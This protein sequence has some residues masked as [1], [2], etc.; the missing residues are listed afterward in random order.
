MKINKRILVCFTVLALCCVNAVKLRASDKWVLILDG[1]FL[2]K[3]M[4]HISEPIK[5]IHSIDFIT[6]KGTY[7]LLESEDSFKLEDFHAKV[8]SHMRSPFPYGTYEIINDPS[9]GSNHF[10]NDYDDSFMNPHFDSR[11]FS[12]D[13]RWINYINN[14]DNK[15][16]QWTFATKDN[17]IQ[18]RFAQYNKHRDLAMYVSYNDGVKDG[19]KLSLRMNGDTICLENFRKGIRIQANCY[20]EDKTLFF[21]ES[22]KERKEEIWGDSGTKRFHTIVQIDSLGHYNGLFQKFNY[23]GSVIE[24]GEYINYR[25]DGKWYYF[26]DN[27]NLIKTENYKQDKIEGK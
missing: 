19:Y 14:G 25:R 8:L 5:N 3:K 17:K 20:D 24:K 4:V 18:G 9:P 2:R 1:H 11:L 23:R 22:M 15:Y 26:D 6:E 12:I 21:Y 10:S 27:G 13:A 7:V 16:C